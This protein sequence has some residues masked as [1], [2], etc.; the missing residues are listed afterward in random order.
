[1]FL[2][3]S[4]MYDNTINT[5]NKCDDTHDAQSLKNIYYKKIYMCLC[6]CVLV[7]RLSG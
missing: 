6:F 1:M 4:S 2:F 7:E 5:I 3:R